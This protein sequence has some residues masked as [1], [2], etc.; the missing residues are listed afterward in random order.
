MKEL[1]FDSLYY[2]MFWKETECAWYKAVRK[3][4]LFSNN[5]NDLGKC[6]KCTMTNIT[7]VNTFF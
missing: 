1:L 6:V 4:E 7:E 3:E 2:R 5:S